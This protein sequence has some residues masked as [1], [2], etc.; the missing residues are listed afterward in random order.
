MER[1]EVLRGTKG[2][3]LPEEEEVD[4]GQTKSTEDS[5]KPVNNI[6]DPSFMKFWLHFFAMSIPFVLMNTYYVTSAFFFL[7]AILS[8]VCLVCY[9][10]GS[11]KEGIQ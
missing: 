6:L 5:C 9:A 1:R 8:C 2:L 11:V 10:D 3:L 4:V 7:F